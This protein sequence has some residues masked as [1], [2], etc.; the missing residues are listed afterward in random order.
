AVRLI[1]GRFPNFAQVIP[2]KLDHQVTVSRDMLTQ[3]LKRASYYTAKTG[4]T[5]I[6]LSDG[7]LEV[8]ALA[9]EAGERNEPI[10]CSY[11]GSGV[12]AGFNYRYLLDVLGVIEGDDVVLEL[13]DTESP[14]VIRDPGRAEALFIV[15]PMQL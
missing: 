1:P 2:Q 4:N 7:T 13:I 15:M 10:P 8:Y 11:G 14:T 6:S 12:S 5:R 9:P 3:A